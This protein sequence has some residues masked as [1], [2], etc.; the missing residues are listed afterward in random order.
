MH[1]L[2]ILEKDLNLEQDYKVYDNE[3]NIRDIRKLIFSNVFSY[4][5]IL[6]KRI[7]TGDEKNEKLY[8]RNMRG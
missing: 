6:K 5:S 2:N 4:S 1:S 3:T 7:I 8:P